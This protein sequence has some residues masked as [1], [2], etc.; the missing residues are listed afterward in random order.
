MAA[1]LCPPGRRA[2]QMDIALPAVLTRRCAVCVP[3]PRHCSAGTGPATGGFS[4]VP[5][6]GLGHLPSHIGTSSG[7]APGPAG[8]QCPWRKP[9][10]LPCR[11]GSG[12]G[13][14]ARWCCDPLPRALPWQWIGRQPRAGAGVLEA[15]SVEEEGRQGLGCGRAGPERGAGRDRSDNCS[16]GRE[17]KLGRAARGPAKSRSCQRRPSQRCR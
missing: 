12:A 1:V 6:P 8:V 16:H 10:A 2:R 3:P 5:L 7:P 17:W 4:P 13:G 9:P 11:S 15:W 14:R